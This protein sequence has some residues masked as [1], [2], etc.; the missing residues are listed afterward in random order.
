MA[1]AW[2]L[3]DQISLCVPPFSPFSSRYKQPLQALYG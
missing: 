2:G 3:R 1:T